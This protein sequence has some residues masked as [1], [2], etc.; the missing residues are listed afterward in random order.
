M[1]KLTYAIAVTIALL[2]LN[3]KVY[4]EGAQRDTPAAHLVHS[5]A[6]PSGA[7]VPDATYHFEIHVGVNSVSGVS[8]EI[9]PPITVG[10]VINVTNRAGKKL[11]ASVN[12]NGS[13]AVLLFNEPV[14]AKTTIGVELTEVNTH[15]REAHT[16]LFPVSAKIGSFSSDIPLG[17]ARV[18]TYK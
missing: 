6:H 15:T 7:T 14:P 13:K 8:I 10:K 2:S 4:A 9:P 5:N 16:W 11:N 18:Q 1:K 3:S 17:L 12:F